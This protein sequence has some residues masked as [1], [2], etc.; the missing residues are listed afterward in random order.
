MTSADIVRGFWEAMH[1]ND[2]SKTAHD[3]L[4]PDFIGMWPQTGEVIHGPGQYAAVNDAFSGG[5]T[6]RF[7]EVSLL[8]SGN[9]VVTDMRVLNAALEVSIHA[10]TFHEIE[11]K[12]IRRQ[13][14]YWPD[15]YPVPAWRAGILPVDRTLAQW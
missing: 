7:E 9:R 12:L 11:G 13:T 2:F 1:S 5:G 15:A 3:W 14:E 8:E 10:I 4:A 6:W